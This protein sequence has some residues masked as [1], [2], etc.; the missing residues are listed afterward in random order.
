MPRVSL[1]MGV[2]DGERYL[3]EAVES[4]LA[5]TFADLEL[6]VVDDA[7]S[8]ATSA[9]LAGFSDP[10][11][12]VL[13]TDE[14][15]GLTRSLNRA[16]AACTGELV[17]RQDA[18]DV[19]DRRRI[20]RQVAHLDAHPEV[21]LCGTWALTVDP[22]GR[23]VGVGR[24]PADAEALAAGLR[25]ENKIFHGSILGRRRLFEELGGYR[26]AFRYSQDY[27]LYLRA[28]ER[29]R[30]TN[31][32]E[33]LYRL[34]FHDGAISSTR[35]ELQH[36]YRELARLL[37]AQRAGRG[38]DDLD[39]GAD[40]EALLAAVH[41]EDDSAAFWRQRAMYRRLVGDLRGYRAA[42]REVVR[43]ER[44]DRRAWAQLALSLG[45]LRAVARVERLLGGRR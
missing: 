9:I 19:S 14:N 38:R 42:L 27:D 10:R 21:G 35:H 30:L 28:V 20:E 17:G 45:G 25:E 15:L 23:E 44:G 8:D 33:P 6:V 29:T 1:I 24:P 32:P 18:D 41:V 16:L 5:Q 26:E 4:V 31:V 2:H 13:R 39:D 34:R 36:R 3:A 22:E 12:V 37:A 40:P 43:R 7:S 11:L